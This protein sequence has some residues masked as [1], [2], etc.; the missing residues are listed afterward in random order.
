MSES[1]QTAAVV[2]ETSQTPFAAHCLRQNAS[3]KLQVH[4]GALTPYSLN[5][6]SLEF[7]ALLSSCGIYDLG[8]RTRIRITGED[9]VRW[10]NG[11]VTN[12]VQSLPAGHL[13]YTFILNA[14]GRIQGDGDVLS[15]ADH[16]LLET[17]RS[18]AAHIL[19]HLDRFII[20]DD[21]EL[22]ELDASTTALGI[23]GPQAPEMLRALGLPDPEPMQ[24]VTTDSGITVAHTYGVLVPRYEIWFPEAGLD[25]VL[26]KLTDAG[27]MLC[28]SAATE[29]LRILEG[30]PQYGVDITDRH[31][32]QETNQTRALNFSK[33]CYLGQEIVERIRSRATV[34]RSL[35]QFELNGAVPAPG[36]ELR[37]Q[38]EERAMGE[39]S[40][41]AKYQLAQQT[42]I[43]AL[44]FVRNE[45]VERKSVI[46]YDGGIAV[47]LEAP[48]HFTVS[49]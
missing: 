34:H 14:Q 13:N 35:R 27:A 1:P 12:T 2:S 5:D 41:I 42:R 21:V 45:F 18:Q 37:V 9:R 30:I 33:G 3:T 49:E 46:E 26:K 40:S 43:L 31:L 22:H 16:L 4:R 38:G 23:A 29:Q 8:Y 6:P 47:A 48:P 10:L 19:E 11:M 7:H 20:M 32:P 39:L 24:V 36:C 28:G 17:D 25:A 15:H 44:G